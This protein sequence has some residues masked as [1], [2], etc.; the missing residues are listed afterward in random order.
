[1][2]EALNRRIAAMGRGAGVTVLP[3][4]RVLE[5]PEHPGRM[6]PE[7]TADGIHPSVEGYRRLG[8]LAFR[9]PG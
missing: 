6:K 1:V 4:H 5:D 9:P 8:A 3:F 7:W 2:I